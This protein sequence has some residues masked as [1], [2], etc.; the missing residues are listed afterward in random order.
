MDDNGS[1]AG[2]PGCKRCKQ[3][4]CRS[5]SFSA[6]EIWKCEDKTATST[7]PGEPIDSKPVW[8]P[9]LKRLVES[10]AQRPSDFQR[11]DST[12]RPN[13]MFPRTSRSETPLARLNALIQSAFN[14]GL[15]ACFQWVGPIES[16]DGA[17]SS[18]SM[19]LQSEYRMKVG[20]SKFISQGVARPSKA[21]SS[22]RMQNT[23]LRKNF[24]VK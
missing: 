7:C 10:T 4:D 5:T 11:T 24:C 1:K 9:E 15:D 22:T 20:N 13:I 19:A 6:K 16:G 18:L 14:L 17:G 21:S 3:G 23:L 8:N 12:N 2:G